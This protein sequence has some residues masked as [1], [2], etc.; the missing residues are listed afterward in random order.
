[1]HICFITN[2]YPVPGK[3]HGGIGTFVYT[4]A[5]A[6][7][8]MGVQVTV[9][10]DGDADR[11]Y[12]DGE[13]TIH[14]VRPSKW[15]L[16]KFWDFY[17]RQQKRITQIH[18]LNP[19]DI[20]EG[21]ELYFAWLPKI[22]GIKYVIRLHGGHHFFSKLL[23]VPT[24]RWRA[25]QEKKS[26][27]RAD[28]FVAVTQFV[29]DGT[30]RY[31]PIPANRVIKIFY[32]VN[33]AKFYNAD[34]TRQVPYKIVFAGTVVEKKGIRQLIMAMPMIQ[35]KFPK[36]TLDIYGRDWANADG[37]SYIGSLQTYIS[38]AS[39]DS[40]SFK[41]A[42]LHQSL[43]RIYETAHICA[44]PSHMETQGIVVLETMSMGKAV[45]FSTEGPG[46]ETIEHLKDG[47]IAD[48]YSPKDIAEKIIYLFSHAG[49]EQALGQNARTKM[50][51]KYDL[52]VVTKLNLEFYESLL[53]G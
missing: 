17:G 2:E 8:A 36:A 7:T 48:P 33:C 34:H 31:L 38:E 35:E 41:G 24:K 45:L 11:E 23:N 43:P 14:H 25:F 22:P 51:E 39:E 32:P 50:L 44:F 4:L 46:P 15:K 28:H 18:A 12:K 1:M 52:P 29:L 26:F 27:K 21:A 20:I 37:S 16:A 9:A 47:L 19:I 3:P 5:H 40:I 13:V 42:V 49:L 10:G 30:R 6:L 53:K